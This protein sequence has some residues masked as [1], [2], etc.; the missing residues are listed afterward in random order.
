MAETANSTPA[1]ARHIIAV[2]RAT[3]RHTE[4]EIE[5]FRRWEAEAYA[6]EQASQA[7]DENDPKFAELW[8]KHADLETLISI[9]PATTRAAMLVKARLGRLDRV[10][11]GDGPGEALFTQ[12]IDY[13]AE[14]DEGE[15]QTRFA[16]KG[17]S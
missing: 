15:R 10:R 2:K 7:T 5:A 13:L 12:L 1:P 8:A 4:S 16:V 14:G 11:D 9:T 6:C 17:E 3:S